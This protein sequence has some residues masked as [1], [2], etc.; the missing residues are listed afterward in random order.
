MGLWDSI[1]RALGG[2][3]E[4]KD[5]GLYYFV[6]CDHCGDRVRVRVSPTSELQQE[7]DEKGD[8]VRGYA[9]RKVVI[10]QRCFRPIEVRLTYNSRRREETREI[11]G[12]TFLTAEEFETSRQ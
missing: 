6:R 7:F 12:G 5:N 2:S 1:K 8:A 11:E 4:S 9:V 10:D 3:S